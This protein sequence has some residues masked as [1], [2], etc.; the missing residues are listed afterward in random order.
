[1]METCTTGGQEKPHEHGS[2][3]CAPYFF[4]IDTIGQSLECPEHVNLWA[5]P[6]C[7]RVQVA[8]QLVGPGQ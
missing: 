4:G 3:S 5:G 2:S 6:A 7:F 1:M 8:S